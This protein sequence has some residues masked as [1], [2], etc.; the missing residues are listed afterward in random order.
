M[1]KNPK[2]INPVHPINSKLYTLKNPNP[3]KPYKPLA[4]SLDL[5][6]LNPGDIEGKYQRQIGQDK[7]DFLLLAAKK[8]AVRQ[9]FFWALRIVKQFQ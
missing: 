6:T 9:Q 1:S 3:Y 4:L 5:Q 7:L 8:E 2:P